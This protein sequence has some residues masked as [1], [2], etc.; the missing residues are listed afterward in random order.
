[1]RG[2]SDCVRE[3]IHEEKRHEEA[4]RKKKATLDALQQKVCIFR[5]LVIDHEGEGYSNPH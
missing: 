4:R 2:D 3:L 5:R 1:M